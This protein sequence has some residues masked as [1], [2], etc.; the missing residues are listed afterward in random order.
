MSDLAGVAMSIA[1]KLFN[2]ARSSSVV[3][4]GDR[5]AAVSLE[6]EESGRW[7]LVSYTESEPWFSREN[8]A[9]FERVAGVGPVIDLARGS[10]T[11][12]KLLDLPKMPKDEAIDTIRHIEKDTAPFDLRKA[13]VDVYELGSSPKSANWIRVIM[14]SMDGNE[15]ER[16]G[17]RLREAG[18]MASVVSVPI[19]AIRALISR[20]LVLDKSRPLL[21]A[22]LEGNLAGIHVFE[23]GVPFFTR[24]V[25]FAPTTHGSLADTTPPGAAKIE[26]PHLERLAKEISRSVEYFHRLPGAG[27]RIE[28]V[29]LVGSISPEDDIERRLSDLVGLP[30]KT[31]DPFEDF[32]SPGEDISV[33]GPAVCIAIGAVI[34]GPNTINLA[35][36]PSLAAGGRGSANRAYFLGAAALAALVAFT[37]VGVTGY[38]DD[39]DAKIKELEAEVGALE[40]KKAEFERLEGLLAE[41]KEQNALLEAKLENHPSMNAA[42]RNFSRTLAD[43]ASSLPP[44]VALTRLEADFT[45]ARAGPSLKMEGIAK[46]RRS[47]GV[48]GVGDF[49]EG[50]MRSSAGFRSAAILRADNGDKAGGGA[51]T[52]FEVAAVGPDAR[53]KNAPAPPR[54]T[55]GSEIHQDARASLVA[56]RRK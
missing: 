20:S 52:R 47:G 19:V 27:R 10:S 25:C 55:A 48:A 8:A 44:D 3:L 11:L 33:R 9:R 28:S 36:P 40:N 6:P 23:G 4:I 53:E 5:A 2:P 22:H 46:N 35:R 49:I 18:L 34:D 29:Y 26:K 12:V 50:L 24:E 43:I 15:A 51:V 30:F 45:R 32:I 38:F 1:E 39:I 37:G 54:V 7:R 17:V 42:G 16:R 41:Q 56:L 13:R 21:F 31:Y 14:A